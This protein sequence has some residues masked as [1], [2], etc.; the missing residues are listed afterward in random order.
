MSRTLRAGNHP[1]EEEEPACANDEEPAPVHLE[2]GHRPNERSGSLSSAAALFPQSIDT[3]TSAAGN[4]HVKKDEAVS[5][6]QF[7]VIQ[8]RERTALSVNHE[9][10]DRHFTGEQKCH[11]SSKE[12]K[13]YQKSS[14][15][16]HPCSDQ[17]QTMQPALMRSRGRWEVKQLLRTMFHEQQANDNAQNAQEDR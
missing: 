5:H 2:S 13:E 8:Y 14:R 9:I 11:W 4:R 7:A 6:G 3:P 1:R 16:F 17:H 12:T 15:K 10:S